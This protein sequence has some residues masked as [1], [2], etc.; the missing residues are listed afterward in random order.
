MRIERADLVQQL[1][2]RSSD[3]LALPFF[4]LGDILRNHLVVQIRSP[5]PRHAFRLK[6]TAA[7]RRRQLTNGLAGQWAILGAHANDHAPIRHRMQF[8]AARHTHRHHRRS[9]QIDLLPAGMNRRTAHHLG[10][11]QGAFH[12]FGIHAPGRLAV[13][14]DARR[15]SC[16]HRCWRT[17]PAFRPTHRRRGRADIQPVGRGR[18]SEWSS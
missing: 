15:P 3:A 8:G 4:A 18:L 17:P 2:G 1:I 7:L 5:R 6:L 12:I 13:L 10:S 16:R 14:I 11:P 9:R